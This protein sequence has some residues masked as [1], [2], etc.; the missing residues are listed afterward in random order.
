MRNVGEIVTVKETLTV[1]GKEYLTKGKQ[2]RVVLSD[3]EAGVCRITTN[4]AGETVPY[5]G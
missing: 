1:N 3:E 5:L 4:F 2:Y